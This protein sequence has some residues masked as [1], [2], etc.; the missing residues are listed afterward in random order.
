MA[1]NDTNYTSPNPNT[2]Y[3]QFTHLGANGPGT[4]AAPDNHAYSPRRGVRQRLAHANARV[5]HFG[6]TFLKIL[7]FLF[8]LLLI[9]QLCSS[10]FVGH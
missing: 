6:W 4:Y 9:L 7:G 1:H 10:L 5:H 2:A 8:L 3:N